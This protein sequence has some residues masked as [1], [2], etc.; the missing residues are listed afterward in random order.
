MLSQKKRTNEFNIKVSYIWKHYRLEVTNSLIFWINS[1][2]FN[3]R[4]F[5]CI[6]GSTDNRLSS[7]ALIL[8]SLLLIKTTVVV[9]NLQPSRKMLKVN[10]KRN[11]SDSKLNT[12]INI[13]FTLITFKLVLNCPFEIIIYWAIWI[14]NFTNSKELWQV[15]SSFFW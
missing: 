2:Y 10:W 6:I 9:R 5:L 3:E 1:I 4:Y 11:I 14:T 13:Q 7:S 15:L 12:E 8:I